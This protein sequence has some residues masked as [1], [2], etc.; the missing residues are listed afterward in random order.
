MYRVLQ[1]QGTIIIREHDHD[2]EGL[3]LVIDIEHMLYDL[4][5]WYAILV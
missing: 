3:S 2:I 1:Q 5:V 4:Q